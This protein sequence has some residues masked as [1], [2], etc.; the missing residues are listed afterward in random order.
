LVHIGKTGGVTLKNVLKIGC[1][2]RRAFR[3]RKTCA[4]QWANQ[5]ETRLS[6]V[7]KGYFHYR[8]IQPYDA[9]E[10]ATGLVFTIRHPVS[11]LESWF[12]YVSPHNCPMSNFSNKILNCRNQQAMMENPN[13]WE[14]AFFQGCFPIVQDL[15]VA[16]SNPNS[17]N[18]TRMAR[19]ALR[20]RGPE[21]VVGH[22]AANYEFYYQETLKKYPNL[23][24]HVIRTER[25]W[26]DTKALD[27]F[28]GGDGQF[29]QDGLQFSHGSEHFS[30]QS[31]T[32][33]AGTFL[34]C[35]AVH[36]ELAVYKELVERAVNL[37]ATQK[38]GTWKMALIRC[39]AT[40]W[41]GL[42]NR[43]GLKES[44]LL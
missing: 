20:G 18:C 23:L 4:Q 22:L 9:L 25:L 42:L 39:G 6:Q 26:S 33:R 27:I 21:P 2:V 13:G 15:A 8:E 5:T 37:N 11:R 29:V 7:T 40:S 31:M 24:V 3:Q 38:L 14:A 1:T 30:D 17:T 28:L 36:K 41:E 10:H 12:R 44:N 43:C 32:S 19:A 34:L 16:F 35:C